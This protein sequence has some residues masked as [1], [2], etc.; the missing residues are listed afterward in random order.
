MYSE[1]AQG[2]LALG[3]AELYANTGK[4]SPWHLA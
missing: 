3:L 2:D 4:D 1:I